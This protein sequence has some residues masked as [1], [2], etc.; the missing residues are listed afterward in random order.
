M[1][2]SEFSVK[3][4]EVCFL[5]SHRLYLD[6]I[7]LGKGAA[8]FNLLSSSLLRHCKIHSVMY[9]LTLLMPTPRNRICYTFYFLLKFQVFGGNFYSLQIS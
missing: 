5:V 8:V 4:H 9:F 7:K 6:V 2:V 3:E 1:F